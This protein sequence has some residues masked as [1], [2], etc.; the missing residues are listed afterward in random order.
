MRL[1]LVTENPLGM[2]A[3]SNMA[4][5]VA[6]SLAEDEGN[7]VFML[8]LVI[9]PSK[10]FLLNKYFVLGLNEQKFGSE[11]LDAAI[12]YS[13][14]DVVLCFSPSFSPMYK[15]LRG[16]KVKWIASY[17]AFDSPFLEDIPTDA[18]LIIT[19][20]R[21]T[22][23]KLREEAYIEATYLPWTIDP[24]YKKVDKAEARG[25]IGLKKDV[26]YFGLVSDNKMYEQIPTAV[27]SFSMAFKG[28]NGVKLAFLCPPYL[29]NGTMIP[30]A[31]KLF[32][33]LEQT[34]FLEGIEMLSPSE[35][36]ANLILNSWDVGVTAGTGDYDY[37]LLLRAMATGKAIV[38]NRGNPI[39][40][41]VIG[42]AGLGAENNCFFR[43]SNFRNRHCVSPIDLKEKMLLVYQDEE[44][45]KDLGRKAM[46][47]FKEEYSPIKVLNQWKETIMEVGG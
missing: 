46:D 32:G 1:L 47:R 40:R 30:E 2:G 35:P 38:Y 16:K 19:N 17:D 37:Q 23:E 13:K 39:H 21:N 45:R 43:D 3:Y 24:L 20:S 18:D 5:L 34:S 9:G 41:E 15:Q 11:A 27:M 22:K 28:N 6:S 14:P 12:R 25:Q 26:F 42:E 7:K 33:V 10:A 29:A 8:P 4:H 44:L 36:V 31:C